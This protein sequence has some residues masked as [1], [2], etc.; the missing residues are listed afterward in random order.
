MHCGDLLSAKSRLKT[1]SEAKQLFEHWWVSR[2]KRDE[3]SN[4]LAVTA[5][6]GSGKTHGAV[7]WHYDRVVLNAKAPR[8]VYVMPIYEMIWNTAV[9][10][11]DKVLTDYGLRE[12]RDYTFVGSPIPLCRFRRAGHEVHFLS[13]TRPDKIKA[14]EFSHGVMDEPGI[15]RKES[16]DRL[17]ERVRDQRAVANQLLLAGTPEGMTWFAD[18]FDSDG[19]EGWVR[20][21]TRDASLVRRIASTGDEIRLRR[22][23]LSTYDNEAFLPAGYIAGLLDSYRANPAYVQA[24]IEGKFC[25]LVTGGCYANYMPRVHDV[26]DRAADAQLTLD[27]TFDF[28]AD[29]LAW[30]SLQTVAVE[31]FGERT[32]RRFALHEAGLGPNTLDEACVEFAAKHPPV[33][34]YKT[35][36]RIFGDSSGWSASHKTRKNDYEAVKYYLKELGYQRVEICAL[37]FNPLE[38]ESVDAL[39]RWFLNRELVVCRRC[40]ALRRSLVSTRWK[41]GEKRIEKKAGETHTHHS[42][43]VKY[44][45]Y[46]ELEGSSRIVRAFNY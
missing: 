7:Q 41:E 23:R 27:L 13:A 46:A 18:E 42:D 26:D 3:T 37:K 43:A 24:Y 5:G 31:E 33:L 20:H 17:R 25:P 39:N 9:P 2:A 4:L 35:P 34:F 10:T 32:H 30:V 36:I 11:W 1:S 44:Y 22:F 45:A 28:N 40:S 19:Q 16:Y 14:V 21:T 12:G 6:L 38:T 29:P 15:S 8:S